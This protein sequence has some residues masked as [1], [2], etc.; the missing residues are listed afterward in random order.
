MIRKVIIVVLTLFALALAVSTIRGGRDE[1]T[2]WEFGEK[3][4]L[5]MHQSLRETALMYWT[6]SD[7]SIPDIRWSRLGFGFVR[8]RMYTP[9]DNTYSCTSYAV[10]SPWWF[11]IV[12]C[13]TYPLIAFVRGPLRRWRRRRKGLCVGC[14]YNLTGSVSGVC[15]EFGE[16]T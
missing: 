12:V 1:W 5:W 8:G 13:G 4:S 2:A 10:F 15:P 9:P 3:R 14:G 11:G 6:V 7:P 16:P